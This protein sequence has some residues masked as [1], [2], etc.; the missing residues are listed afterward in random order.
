[1]SIQGKE[2]SNNLI[3]VRRL[4]LNTRDGK[5]GCSFTAFKKKV[6]RTWG[7]FGLVVRGRGVRENP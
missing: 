4:H 5:E 1:M 3:R 2:T 6:S 7:R